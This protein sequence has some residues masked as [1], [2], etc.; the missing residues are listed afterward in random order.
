M[1]WLRFALI[2]LIVIVLISVVKFFLRK[3]LNI[4][5]EKRGIFSYNHINK[6]HR[7]I[8]WGLRITSMITLF[9]LFYLSSYQD[10]SIYLLVFALVVFNL[11]DYV[12]RAFFEL[13][14]TQ[15][16]KQSILTIS[17]MFLLII[18]IITVIQFDLLSP[19]L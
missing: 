17:E 5:K 4:E 14:Y 7:K 3:I 18:A 12:V 19:I 1:F 9:I 10:A 11:F 16:P 13:K 6:L 2:V 15:N 8:D